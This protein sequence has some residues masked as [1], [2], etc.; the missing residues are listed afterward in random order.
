[1]IA[2]D[3]LNE[4]DEETYLGMMGRLRQKEPTP[5]GKRYGATAITRRQIIA[6]TNPSGHDWVWDRFVNKRIPGTAFYKSSS[7]DNPYLPV[8]Y[9]DT[10]LTYPEAWVKRYVLC[11]FDDFAGQIYEGW[12][13]K[14]VIPHED[15]E[16][17][18][19][20]EIWHAMDPGMRNPTGALWAWID[21][22]TGRVVV[23]HEYQETYTGIEAHAKAWRE[24]E[25]ENNFNVTWRVADP[26]VMKYS[27]D[28]A[29]QMHD[30][31]RRQGFTFATGPVRYE[32]RIP[33]LGALIEQ[34]RLYASDRCPMF[35]E[36]VQNY[37]WTDL[38]P[39]ARMGKRA[40]PET[41]VKKDEHLVDC[42]Q[43]LASRL[44][45]ARPGK[46]PPDDLTP[47]ELFSQEAVTQI[48]KNLSD[49]RMPYG[50]MEVIV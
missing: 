41:P 15:I 8:E 17:P 2:W 38:T 34:G 45:V 18:E 30:M 22:S 11:Q 3:E 4:F 40:A 33:A 31:Y 12:G 32:D 29:M 19:N 42:G 43:Y 6:A 46:R 49:K 1:M 16:L 24:I 44:V 28:T 26:T 13:H 7:L 14:F 5:E 10:L 48:K 50:N 25:K 37:R 36:Q 21:R 20:A 35:F 27:P 9:V 47:R 23:L 39:A